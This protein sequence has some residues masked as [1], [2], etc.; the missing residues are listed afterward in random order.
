MSIKDELDNFNNQLNLQ[1]FNLDRQAKNYKN[2]KEIY[3]K[4]LAEIKE[5]KRRIEVSRNNANLLDQ[6]FCRLFY[7]QYILPEPLFFGGN[8]GGYG[9]GGG[10]IAPVAPTYFYRGGYGDY[11]FSHELM[12]YR[13]NIH[14]MNA[15]NAGLDLPTLSNQ[16]TDTLENIKEYQE[17]IKSILSRLVICLS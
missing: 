7:Y 4:E 1:E 5:K 2:F 12:A 11:A 13:D 17:K 16:I 14:Q 9:G 10:M 6:L 8:G 3:K 15:E